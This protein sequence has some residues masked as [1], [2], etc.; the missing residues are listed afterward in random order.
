MKNYLFYQESNDKLIGI[1]IKHLG[2]F[3]TAQF[4]YSFSVV[5]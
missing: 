4:V 3:V 5:H 1:A 2:Y